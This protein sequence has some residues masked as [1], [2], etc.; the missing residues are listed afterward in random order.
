LQLPTR[1]VPLKDRLAHSINDDSL[2]KQ[3][4]QKYWN[5]GKQVIQD[6]DVR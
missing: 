6:R 4:S 5:L 1:A 3:T 2:G